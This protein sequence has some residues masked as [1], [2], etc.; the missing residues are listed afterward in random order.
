MTDQNQPVRAPMANGPARPQ[1]ARHETQVATRP[2]QPPRSID[3][4]PESLEFLGHYDNT[5][6]QNTELKQDKAR[7]Q[8]MVRG[9][10]ARMKTV[11][12]ELA[13]ITR[14]RN[15]YQDVYQQLR[16]HATEAATIMIEALDERGGGR[17]T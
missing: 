6:A 14:E 16:A 5:M 3:R 17:G 8:T 15:F 12:E 11:N 9:L 4:S 7:L 13:R 2:A 10:E 1:P